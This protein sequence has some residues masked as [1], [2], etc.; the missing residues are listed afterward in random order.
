MITIVGVYDCR[1]LEMSGMRD[2]LGCDDSRDDAGN[3]KRMMGSVNV[4]YT[5]INSV[6]LLALLKD[7]NLADY[8]LRGDSRSF[9]VLQ[10]QVTDHRHARMRSEYRLALLM[11][12]LLLLLLLLYTLIVMYNQNWNEQREE[13]DKVHKHIVLRST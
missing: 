10:S 8:R 2:W 13:D 11:L 9:L 12:L 3:V 1:R 4:A 6:P 5:R 7:T